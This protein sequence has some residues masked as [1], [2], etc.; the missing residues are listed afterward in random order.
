M[1]SI[2]ELRDLIRACGIPQTELAVQAEVSPS[3]LSRILNGRSIARLSTL[4]SLDAAL[5]EPYRT[6]RHLRVFIS[7]P[8]DVWKERQI[9]RTVV[10]R[11]G[12]DP[13]F[14][15][16]LKLDPILWDDPEAPAPMLANLTPQ[17]C[18]NRGLV[19]PSDC[20]IVVTIFRG[21][22]GP[23]LEK[24]LKKDKTLYL[25]GTEWEF[26][27]ARRGRGDILLYRCT[28]EVTVALNDP[29]FAEKRAQKELVDRFFDWLE[30]PSG[31]WKGGHTTYERPDEFER[32]F[33][34]DLRNL[35]TKLLAAP[36]STS[37]PRAKPSE[38]ARRPNG[39]KL[40][41]PEVPD[42]YREWLKKETGSFELLGIGG[43]QGKSLFLSSVYVP[44][45]TT[46]GEERAVR[47][48][49]EPRETPDQAQLLLHALGRRSLYVPGGP[50]CGKSTFC[51]WVAWLVCERAIPKA[52]VEPPG[53]LVEAL[54]PSLSAKL[55]VLVRL[56]EFWQTLPKESAGGVLAEQDFV[57]I[58]STWLRGKTATA[59]TLD[60]SAF[61]EHG[62]ALFI[63]DGIDEVP[64]SFSTANGDATP[65][66]LL[67]GA[68]SQVVE[69]WTPNGNVLLVTGRPHGLTH[70]DIVR[71]GLDQAPIADLPDEIQELLARRWFRIQKQDAVKGDATAE[72]LVRDIRDREW[73]RPL[74]ANPLMLT[75]MCAIYSDGRRL[76]QDQHQLYDRIIDSVLTKRCP[77][78]RRRDRVRFEL[79]AIAHAM[80]DGKVLGVRHPEPIAQAT[81]DEAEMALRGDR[82]AATQRESVLGPKDARE[83]LLTQSGLLTGYGDRQLAFYHL[84]IQEFLA[85]ERIF[86]L[87]LD[88]LR[89]VFLERAPVPNWRNTLS[90]LFGHYMGAFSVATRPL[91]LLNELVDESSEHSFG[92]QLVIADCAEM[93][94]A[95]G[96]PLDH[97]HGN[98][99]RELLLRSMTTRA[100][101]KER[102]DAGESLG[103]VGDPR[104]DPA[105]WHLPRDPDTIL[106]FVRVAAG[107]F[108]IGSDKKRDRYSQELER[109]QHEVTLP[110]FCIARYPVT[111]GQFAAFV[112]DSGYEPA[113]ADSL[114]GAANT[115]A[116][117]VSWHEALA[118]CAWLTEKLRHWTDAPDTIRRWLDGTIRDGW[119]VTLPSEAEWEKAARGT[120][121]R[122]YP[123]G[124]TFDPNRGNLYE[125][126]IGRVSAVGAFPEGASPSGGLDTS[127]NVWEW[128]RS[129]WGMNWQHPDFAYPYRPGEPRRDDLLAP[130]T[131][132]RV[133]RGGSFRSG[134]YFVRAANR[135]RQGPD[136]REGDVGFRVVVSR[137]LS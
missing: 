27:D 35:L 110:D 26:E 84:S 21:R 14:R 115:P 45:V 48:T 61:L 70:H 101:A 134:D 137:P 88:D 43:S 58:L 50:G 120:D 104:F 18:V 121:G 90:F 39:R 64:T 86:E 105:R 44:L 112:A 62:L 16:H 109:P 119:Q 23:P 118:Y 102:C 46:A 19:R 106:G 116:V 56:R 85:A 30:G 77:E 93:L 37:R 2:D 32:R 11:L 73:L 113:V 66:Q 72:A 127:G 65:R 108:V 71:L 96:Y 63:F 80:H 4:R 100:S 10:E 132:S 33:E 81:F 55:P 82:A 103:K 31:G 3:T 136:V 69:R 91:A 28:A 111:V 1:K 129:V 29:A 131:M 68:L 52:D 49:L 41:R 38:L 24:P 123:W 124:D 20:D 9:A 59:A 98:R 74:A 107:P 130:D 89:Q 57:T 97:T 53:E 54:P 126:G 40:S 135:G 25:S 67:L 125:T 8:G 51:N 117:W 47:R 42:A 36:P 122:V 78:T 95:K 87:R 17:E 5:S 92:L 6:S 128:T 34:S 60:L 99:L 12:K 13:A 22:M 75:A 76:P 94:G 79:G 83:D 133:V 15:N 7:S 114:R